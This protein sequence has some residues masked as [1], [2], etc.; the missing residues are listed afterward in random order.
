MT[1]AFLAPDNAY[2]Y[3]HDQTSHTVLFDLTSPGSA[4]AILNAGDDYSVIA[5]Y[6]TSISIEGGVTTHY[7]Q[8]GSFSFSLTTSPVVV[9]PVTPTSTPST[10]ASG[11][12]YSTVTPV[13]STGGRGTTVSIQGGKNTSG[14][15]Q[16]VTLGTTNT[17]AHFT[18]MA[19][20]VVSVS[21]NDGN[22][23]SL[24]LTFDLNTANQMGGAQNMT[25]LWQNPANSEWENAVLG[26]HGTNTTNV[27]YLDYQ[28]S[29]ASFESTYGIS[30]ANLS[31]YLGAYGV[32]TTND[33]VWAVIDHNS[34][35]VA[36][37]TLLLPQDQSVPEP[38]T[39]AMLVGGLGM[40]GL[41]SKRRT[42]A[43]R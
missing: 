24:Q 34:S 27:L 22:V 37:N 41:W 39:W 33:T 3:L 14:S 2:L 9:A 21:G 15:A 23:F 12:S 4:S 36:G 40:L 32:D 30:D 18:A 20:D 8:P 42:R 1:G 26:D 31:L 5:Q 28:G 17:G 11:T 13:T 7:G 35:F 6:E 10:V 16:T 19:S 25:L 38:S 43:T 29:F